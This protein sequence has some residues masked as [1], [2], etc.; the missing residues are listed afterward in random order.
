MKTPETAR[1]T[2]VVTGCAGFLGSHVTDALT[3]DGWPI[4]GFDNLATGDIA[5]CATAAGAGRLSFR[6]HDVAEPFSDL[7]AP[8]TALCV[9]LAAI[10][11]PAR[12]SA[13]PIETFRTAVLGA[14]HAA[15]TAL[16]HGA[17]L[18]QASTSEVYGAAGDGPLAETEWGRVNP[19]GPR[20]CYAEG[21]RAAE[22]HL[23]DLARLRGLDL[24]LAR[25][26]N[27]YGPR[28]DMDDGRV[29]S[30]FAR[31]ALVGQPL[32]VFGDG[33]QTRSFC[34]VE[35]ATEALLRLATG[36]APGPAPINIGNP[37][38]VTILMLAEMVR[39]L[40]GTRSEIVFRPAPPEDPPRRR[41]DISRADAILGWRPK[42]CLKAGLRLTIEDVERQLSAKACAT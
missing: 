29:V 31:Q 26:F 28:M 41:P 13:A 40:V 27:V 19:V 30:A 34:Y 23:T 21:K 37:E 12:Y 20:A 8:D 5:K 11:A 36:P 6:E 42:T 32:T 1:G 33:S 2:A 24:R 14:M 10:A 17:P 16:A 35:D 4:Q 3:A 25:L 39:D 15:E 38:E 18:L 9:N 22:T 7:A